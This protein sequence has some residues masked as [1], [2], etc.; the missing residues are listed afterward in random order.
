MTA[1]RVCTAIGLLII[2]C[3]FMELDKTNRWRTL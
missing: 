3:Q 2:A 1:K